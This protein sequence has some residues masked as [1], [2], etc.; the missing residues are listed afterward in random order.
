MPKRLLCLAVASW[1]VA[2]AANALPSVV[3]STN[4]QLQFTNFQFFS[5]SHSVA[6]SEISVTP[7][8]D[9]IL[10]S[11]PVTASNELRSFFVSYDVRALGDGIVG[12]SLRLA[13]EIEHD[14]F[15]LVFATKRILGGPRDH[16]GWDEHDPWKDKDPWKTKDWDD[17]KG[18]TDGGRG[19]KDRDR[20]VGGG[21]DREGDDFT[22]DHHD[23]ELGDRRTL[24]FLKTAQWQ[25]GRRW[26]NH[27]SLGLG[28]DGAIR[29]A[30]AGFAVQQTLRV[31]EHVVVSGRHGDATWISSANRFAT[32]TAV[33]EPGTAGL[34]L[35]GLGLL[36][37]RSRR[38]D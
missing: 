26:C 37:R 17:G 6:E 2:A 32:L 15:G 31:V 24:A 33:P 20:H 14:A 5:P 18:W 34:M 35:L 1:L 28:N 4:G 12:A 8:L 29:L 11:G 36:A 7:L 22:D 38:S 27:P 9:G 19:W 21:W 30:E 25:A 13:S 23:F 3:Y 10:L 16:Y